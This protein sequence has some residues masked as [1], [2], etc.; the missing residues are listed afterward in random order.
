[1]GRNLFT[2]WSKIGLLIFSVFHSIIRC[3][4][5]IKN[6]KK[7]ALQ[8][9]WCTFI[10]LRSLSPSNWII[11]HHTHTHICYI[12]HSTHTLNNFTF[13]YFCNI[14]FYFIIQQSILTRNYMVYNTVE[15]SRHILITSVLLLSKK[16]PWR[17]PHEW[18]KLV[19]DQ[20]TIKIYQ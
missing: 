14:L 2:I 9:Y 18:P 17:W 11:I 7:N 20:N 15:W 16:P 19:G 12:H 4:K 10:V 1:M 3:I 8:F 5:C 6:Q 13:L